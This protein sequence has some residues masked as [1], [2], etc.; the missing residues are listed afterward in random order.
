MQTLYTLDLTHI[1]H[2]IIGDEFERGI[3]GGQRKRVNVALELV[4]DPK[5]LFLDEPTSGL[6]SV[7]ATKLCTIL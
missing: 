1:Q 3:S 7:S 6:D 4:A 2:S 5:L